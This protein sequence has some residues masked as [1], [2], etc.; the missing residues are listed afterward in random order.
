MSRHARVVLP[1]EPHH[2]THRGNNRQ[3]VFLDDQDRWSYL[4]CLRRRCRLHQVDILAWCLMSNH[5][6]LVLTPTSEKGLGKAVGETHWI[7]AQAFN[8]RHARVGH[9]W[10]ARYFSTPM[11]ELHMLRCMLYVERNPVRAGLVEVPEDHPWSSARA[12]V[13]GVDRMGLVDAAAWGRRFPPEAWSAMLR[14][15]QADSTVEEIQSGSKSGLP[16]MT[17]RALTIWEQRLG[18]V[19]RPRTRGRPRSAG[20]GKSAT[21]DEEGPAATDSSR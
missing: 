4:R 7:H 9:L 15:R 11:D 12:H 16:L 5:V 6:H 1:G 20:R 21:S 17:E 18:R 19:L 10:H 3:Q 2:I 8:K 14:E 13:D